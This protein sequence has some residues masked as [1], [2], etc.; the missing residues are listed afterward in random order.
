M[1]FLESTTMCLL[2]IGF[3]NFVGS[4]VIVTGSDLNYT[5]L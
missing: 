2:F 3:F 4:K 5:F 1:I